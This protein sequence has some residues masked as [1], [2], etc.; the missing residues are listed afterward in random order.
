MSTPPTLHQ[1]LKESQTNVYFKSTGKRKEI[2]NHLVQ[3]CKFIS[4]YICI[5]VRKG[6]SYLQSSEISSSFVAVLNFSIHVAQTSKVIFLLI[7]LLFGVQIVCFVFIFITAVDLLIFIIAVAKVSV[8]SFLCDWTCWANITKNEKSLLCFLNLDLLPLESLEV[9][10]L[11]Y[12][13]R[14]FRCLTWSFF[15]GSN[16]WERTDGAQCGDFKL[17]L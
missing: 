9:A 14:D 7:M 17:S 11:W 8:C 10:G 12:C 13:S 2:P 5:A 1:W 16:A 15:T 6:T 3:L 4:V